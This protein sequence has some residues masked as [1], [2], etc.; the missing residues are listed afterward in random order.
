[1]TATGWLLPGEHDLDRDL[2][3]GQI[4]SINLDEVATLDRPTDLYAAYLV[5]GSE[6]PAPSVAA[7][8]AL[9]ARPSGDLGPHQ[10]YAIQWWAAMLAAPVFVFFGVRSETRAVAAAEQAERPE[11]SGGGSAVPVSAR[12]VRIWDEEDA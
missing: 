2:P 8:P 7:R 3:P 6:D 12:R 9:R 10:A 5:L 1:V 4:A 11:G